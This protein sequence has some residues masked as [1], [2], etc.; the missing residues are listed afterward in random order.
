MI[1]TTLCKVE[2][3]LSNATYDTSYTFWQMRENVDTGRDDGAAETSAFRG[4][5]TTAVV[6]NSPF[7]A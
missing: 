1:V 7:V 6:T 5:K 2:I 3:Y 4:V